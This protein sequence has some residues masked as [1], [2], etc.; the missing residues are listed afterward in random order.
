V[1]AFL[2]KLETEQKIESNI[3]PTVGC[4]PMQETSQGAD[5]SGI[6][7]Q[8]AS[9]TKLV[10]VEGVHFATSVV[11]RLQLARPKLSEAG[12]RKFKKTGASQN[13][14]GGLVQQG[15][16]TLLQQTVGPNRPRPHRCI[17]MGQPP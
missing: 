2:A 16:E 1:L 6:S 12:R 9:N 3:F 8:R 10:E 17:S 4:L 11:K 13:D 14:A 15:Y 7:M 5:S